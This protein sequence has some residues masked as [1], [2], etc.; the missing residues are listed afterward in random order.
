M[1]E[2]VAITR[3]HRSILLQKTTQLLIHSL[4]LEGNPVHNDIKSNSSVVTACISL[5]GNDFN[6]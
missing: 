3:S 1:E 2:G 5:G 4:R 6:Y